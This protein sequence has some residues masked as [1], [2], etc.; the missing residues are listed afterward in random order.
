[1]CQRDSKT[2]RYSIDG[3]MGPNEFHEGKE[4]KGVRDNA[5]TNIMLAWTLE[6]A[7]HLVAALKVDGPYELEKAYRNMGVTAKEMENAY[8]H[9]REIRRNLSLSISETGVIANHA[10]WFGLK[11][12]D[13]VKGHKIKRNGHERELFSIVYEPGRSDRRIRAVGLDPDDFQ[14]QKQADTMMAYY[15][16]GPNE[17]SRVVGMM[18]YRLPADHLLQNLNHHLPRTSH[19]STLSFIT[20]A[21]VLANAGNASDS[22]HF[23]RQALISDLSD[24]QGGTTAEGIHLGVMG[25]C[26]KGVVTNYAGLDWRGDHLS[27][28]PDLPEEWESLKFSVLVRGDRYCFKITKEVLKLKVVREDRTKPER[29]NLIVVVRGHPERVD[30][31]VDYAFGLN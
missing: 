31:V 11:G 24:I 10:D 4:K 28:N 5:Y 27:I 22:W 14:I 15:N 16:L 12:P 2:G 6:K 18:G 19:G 26:L 3:V 9:W 23:Y 21:M 7:A 29:K 17:V 13:E 30:Y 8:D 1:M 25:G 20:H